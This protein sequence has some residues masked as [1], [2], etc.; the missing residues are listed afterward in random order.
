MMAHPASHHRAVISLPF[1]PIWVGLK[2]HQDYFEVSS[3]RQFPIVPTEGT[4]SFHGRNK[5]FLPWKQFVSVINVI[6][7]LCHIQAFKRTN[8]AFTPHFPYRND[9]YMTA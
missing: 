5:L 2:L 3:E 6:M 4:D 9:G 7:K 8:V 1:L